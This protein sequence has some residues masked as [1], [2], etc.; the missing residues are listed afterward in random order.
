MKTGLTRWF[1]LGLMLI[2][3]AVSGQDGAR[4]GSDDKPT[5]QDELVEKVVAAQAKV[6]TAQQEL[7]E[8]QRKNLQRMGDLQRLRVY[9]SQV[10]PGQK[11][12]QTTL[13]QLRFGTLQLEEP[14][15]K[16]YGFDFVEADPVLRSQLSLPVNEGLV[17]VKVMTNGVADQAG[18]KE[19]DLIAR[20][21]E[22][23]AAGVAQV[24][25]VIAKAE[26]RSVKFDLF[27][28]GKPIQLTLTKPEGATPRTTYWIGVPVAPV[29][30][31]LRSHLPELAPDAGLVVTDVVPESP[32]AKAGVQKN[33]ILI[34]AGGDLLTS[35]EVL[36]ERIQK[37]AGKEIKLDLYRAGKTL[38]LDITPEKHAATSTF[39][40]FNPSFGDLT[41]QNEINSI[42]R[43]QT[44]T[45][46]APRDEDILKNPNRTNA[47]S[48]FLTPRIAD[49]TGVGQNWPQ[50]A[51][52]VPAPTGSMGV[53]SMLEKEMHEL[54]AKIEALR[55]TIDNMKQNLP[56]VKD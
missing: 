40:I 2:G 23:P 10:R 27:R 46:Y 7:V 52:G 15:P 9:G 54:S 36:I 6:R 28:A 24:R 25:E 38:S 20:I 29:D 49:R 41:G 53:N 42:F 3:G 47:A 13:S 55:Q 43:V 32:A 44:P 12:N 33:D 31:T 56:T 11:P 22:Q 37:T 14:F 8:A 51:G 26:D 48:I 1:T 21:N 19:K 50:P 5:S 16:V 35:N 18:I 45:T 17:V 39:E 30:A 34:R 4:L